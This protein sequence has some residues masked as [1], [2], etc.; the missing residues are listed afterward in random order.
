MKS[1]NQLIYLVRNMIGEDEPDGFYTPVETMN[2]VIKVGPNSLY[3]TVI[4]IIYLF[5]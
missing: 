3:F 2:G 1:R 4:V 5:M